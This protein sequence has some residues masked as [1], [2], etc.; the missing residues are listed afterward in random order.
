MRGP[1]DGGGPARLRPCAQQPRRRAEDPPSSPAALSLSVWAPQAG[2]RPSQVCYGAH[3]ARPGPQ[4]LVGALSLPGLVWGPS[5]PTW[6]LSLLGA[7]S[8]LVWALRPEMGP[9]SLGKGPPRSGVGSLGPT[10][11]LPA[12][13]GPSQAC[14]RPSQF[15]RGHPRPGVGPSSPTWA[16]P[17]LVGAFPGSA[18]ES[19]SKLESARVGSF[20]RESILRLRLESG[21]KC[22]DSTALIPGP[23]WPLTIWQWPSQTWRGPLRPDMS[24]SNW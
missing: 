19:E 22:V 23:L 7:L 6:A 21:S 5:D 14:H 3:Q 13:I 2:H 9:S 11:A 1:R 15:G 24:P 20:A 8:G 12:L 18:A 4:T 16:L 10:W 17:A